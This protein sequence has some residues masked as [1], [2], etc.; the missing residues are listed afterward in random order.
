LVLGDAHI[1]ERQP[2]LDELRE[3]NVPFV[4]VS[5][6]Q[7]GYPGVSCDDELGGRLVAERLY[8]RGC[9]R[10]AVLA[11]EK[12]ASAGA[13]RTRGFWT[14]TG[15]KALKSIRAGCCTVASIHRPAA[16]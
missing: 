9:R 15:N 14:S 5:R 6:R 4:L 13:D 12:H 7:P 16:N 1:G 11:G 8:E 3:S 2:L 10:V